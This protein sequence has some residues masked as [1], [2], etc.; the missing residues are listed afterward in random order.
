VWA[1]SDLMV[2]PVPYEGL[3]R[4]YESRSMNSEATPA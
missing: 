4:Y 3:M 1:L 2:E